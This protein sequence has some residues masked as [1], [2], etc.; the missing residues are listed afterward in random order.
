MLPI[1]LALLANAP[2]NMNIHSMSIMLPVP[3][4]RLKMSMRRRSGMPPLTA[5]AYID[6]IM[7]A[8]V[9]GTL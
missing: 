7:K 4:P 3:A 1:V 5:M 6:D 9:I 2:A 8:T